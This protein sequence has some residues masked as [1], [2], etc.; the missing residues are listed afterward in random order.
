MTYLTIPVVAGILGKTDADIM[1]LA[2][3]PDSGV[4]LKGKPSL[5]TGEVQLSDVVVALGLTFDDA[6]GTFVPKEAK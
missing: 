5:R 3:E 4:T 2:M 1:A 6:T